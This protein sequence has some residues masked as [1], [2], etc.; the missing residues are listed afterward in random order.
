MNDCYYINRDRDGCCHDPGNGFDWLRLLLSLSMAMVAMLV[1][2]ALASCK[3][4][5]VSV[6]EYHKEY[7]VRSDTIAKVDSVFLKDSVF[8][9]HN[10]DTVIVNKVLYRDRYRNI[11]KVRTDTLL[12][13]DSVR[14]PYPVERELTKQEKRYQSVGRYVCKAFQW[15][16]AAAALAFLAWLAGKMR[17]K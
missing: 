3:T 7:I 4:K 5:Y 6:P 1:L 13:S 2:Q 16:L 11:Y 15:M 12:R 10:G 14:V 8:V 9:Y 17:N